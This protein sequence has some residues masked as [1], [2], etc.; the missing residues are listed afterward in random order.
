MNVII[1]EILVLLLLMI[2]LKILWPWCIF[3]MK[4][5]DG[6]VVLMDLSEG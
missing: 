3:I 4:A 5:V 1:R 6:T 2:A